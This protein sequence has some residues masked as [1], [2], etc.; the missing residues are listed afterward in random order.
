MK[1]L[2]KTQNFICITFLLKTAKRCLLHAIQHFPQLWLPLPLFILFLLF[3]A[4]ATGDLLFPCI[5]SFIEQNIV[6]YIHS[7]A[8]VVE[9]FIPGHCLLSSGSASTCNPTCKKKIIKQQHFKFGLFVQLLVLH[10]PADI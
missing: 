9:L 3:V 2:H 5:Q 4:F 8:Y 1:K 6:S 10:L 7:F